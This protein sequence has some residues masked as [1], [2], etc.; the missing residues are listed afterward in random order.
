M[1]TIKAEGSAGCSLRDDLMPSMLDLA[2]RTNCRVEVSA[3]DT[4]FWAHPDDTIEGMADAYDRLYPESR[5]VFQ[6]MAK[7]FPRSV[8]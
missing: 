1:L 6:G 5:L 8:K 4:N 7:P 3:N 2:R